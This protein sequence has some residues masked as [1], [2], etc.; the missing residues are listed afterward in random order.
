MVRGFPATSSVK[1]RLL[2]EAQGPLLT[3]NEDGEASSPGLTAWYV[4]EFCRLNS[5]KGA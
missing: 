1:H 5:L 4:A 2:V 3:V